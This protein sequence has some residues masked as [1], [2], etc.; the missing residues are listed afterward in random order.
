VTA[1]AEQAALG[2]LTSQFVSERKQ[3]EGRIERLRTQHTKAIR[4]KSA[5]KNKSQNLLEKV[6]AQE[7]EKE[8]LGRRLNDEKEDAENARAEA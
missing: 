4:D 2:A 7:E 6:T 3:L 5:A 8:D 1:F